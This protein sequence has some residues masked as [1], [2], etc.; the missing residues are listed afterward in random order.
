[1]APTKRNGLRGP[2]FAVWCP[3]LLLIVGS[4]LSNIATLCLSLKL[5]PLVA[6]YRQQ[7]PSGQHH[8]RTPAMAIMDP[9]A[10]SSSGRTDVL[11]KW[12]IHGSFHRVFVLLCA[13]VLAGTIVPATVL[14]S[15]DAAVTKPHLGQQL[16]TLLRD[17]LQLPDW[18]I[19]VLLSAMPL[20]ELRGGVPVGLWMGMPVRNVMFLCVVGNMI[21]IPLILGALRSARMRR[22]L[23]PVLRS[24]RRKTRAL[25]A[26]H[27][28]VGVTAFVGV[29]LPGTGA[30]TGAMVAHFLGMDFGEALTS[31]LAG[32]CVAACIMASLTLAG[33]YGCTIALCVISIALGSRL[34]ALG[35]RSSR[36]RSTS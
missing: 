26:Q 25:R 29:P 36:G 35:R 17:A 32:V 10:A 12:R 31:V 8:I 15:G 34:V 19:L 21:P 28:W 30:W 20:I 16:A 18:A 22:L 14:A 6:G 24:A 1:M 5:P 11:R 33:W 3:G 7:I 27:R 23:T 4:S 13:V 9:C 2:R